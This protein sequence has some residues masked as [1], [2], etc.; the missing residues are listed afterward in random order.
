[1]KLPFLHTNTY[2]YIWINVPETIAI[3]KLTKKYAYKAL[4]YTVYKA[5][6]TSLANVQNKTIGKYQL[7]KYN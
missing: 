5:A 7:Y 2:I 3:N 6:V 1:V 4:K